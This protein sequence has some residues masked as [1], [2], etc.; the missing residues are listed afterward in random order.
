MRS[1]SADAAIPPNDDVHQ[2]LLVFIFSENRAGE[3]VARSMLAPL[4]RARYR[5]MVVERGEDR[6]HFSAGVSSASSPREVLSVTSYLLAELGES[7]LLHVIQ[8]VAFETPGLIARWA[9]ERGHQITS[10]F[11]PAEEYPA[12]VELDLLVVMGGPMDADDE[13]ASPW[14]RPEKHF[15]AEAISGG[16]LV[17]GICL[18]AQIVAEVLGGTVRRNPEREIGWFAVERTL[19]GRQEPLFVNVSETLVVG[20]WHSDTFDLPDGLESLM[21][22]EACAN[23]AF[24]FDGRVVGLQFHVEWTRDSLAVLLAECSGEL[25]SSGR[26]VMSAQEIEDEAADRIDAA[27]GT[28]FAILDAMTAE[29]PGIAGSGA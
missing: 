17:L 18:G 13:V 20:Q 23:Q 24:V 8:H 28:L 21:S 10:S 15:I 1:T 3:G 4:L 9:S 2:S 6:R 19:A 22:S 27:R 26:W 16:K 12:I 25:A 5:P 29:G 11:A 14:L 7:M